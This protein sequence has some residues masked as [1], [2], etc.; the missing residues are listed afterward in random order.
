VAF[1][2][3]PENIIPTTMKKEKKVPHKPENELEQLRLFESK[4]FI[5]RWFFR[6]LFIGG[7][8]A[9]YLLYKGMI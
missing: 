6:I 1:L 2:I 4:L 9:V 8:L 7:I 5:L 3:L